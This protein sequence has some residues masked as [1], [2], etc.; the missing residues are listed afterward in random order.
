M[1]SKKRTRARRPGPQVYIGPSLPDGS[2]TQYTVFKH[3]LPPHV[4]QIKL[5]TPEAQHLIVPV[6]ELS[7]AR[8]RLQRHGK[9]ARAYQE[10]VRKYL[11]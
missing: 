5:S 1:P 3:G 11:T 10:M 4:E 6:A 8:Q 2:L 9:E 7:A